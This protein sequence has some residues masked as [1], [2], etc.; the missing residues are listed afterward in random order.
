MARLFACL[1]LLLLLALAQTAF[2]DDPKPKAEPKLE[3]SK[4]EKA[5]LELTNKER[6]KEKLPPLEPNELLFKAARGHSA[7][8]AKQGELEHVLDGKNPGKRLDDEGYDWTE[9]GENIA[10][11]TDETPADII[12][13]WMGSELH[14]A[15]LLSKDFKQIG[16]GIVKNAKGEVYYT[17]VF[18]TPQKKK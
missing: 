1:S 4:E 16:I 17:Q 11:A 8:M 9:V 12:K 10:L 13:L 18:A 3:M 7:N 15:N 6:A 2:G 5:I 14:K